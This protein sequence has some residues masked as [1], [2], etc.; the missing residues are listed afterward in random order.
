M[1]AGHVPNLADLEELRDRFNKAAFDFPNVDA[2][3]VK[4]PDARHEA[5]KRQAQ[6]ALAPR[7]HARLVQP[8]EPESFTLKEV[9]ESANCLHEAERWAVEL[10]RWIPPSHGSIEQ[11]GGHVYYVHTD[12]ELAHNPSGNSEF[13]HLW[14]CTVFGPSARG[15]E[16]R[17]Q[18][19]FLMLAADAAGLVLAGNGKGDSPRSG[20]LIYL[21]DRQVPLAVSSRR[22]FLGWS[23][24]G[25]KPSWIPATPLNSAPEWW[26][27]RLQHVFLLSRNAV[28]EV[29]EQAHRVFDT[30]GGSDEDT[31]RPSWNAATRQLRLGSVVVRSY[32]RRAPSQFLVLDA[33]QAAD[34]PLSVRRPATLHGLKDTVEALN[35]GLANCRLRF[36]RG[37][38]E[39]S[40]SWSITPV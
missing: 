2:V 20:W 16:N 26:A 32:R 6:A 13:R 29:I 21:A 9:F 19:I 24:F 25:H 38:A 3:V 30:A 33:F 27:V 1:P 34:W 17:A 36:E 15:L 40:I 11:L 7:M 22:Q 10:D 37:A 28:A 39:E 14:D 31:L 23:L 18:R 35:E 8:G 12:R 4:L 5:T